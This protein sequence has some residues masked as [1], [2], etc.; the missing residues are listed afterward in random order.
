MSKAALKKTLTAMDKSQLVEIVCELYD[1]R[2]E[3]QEYLE[4]WLNPDPAKEL[5]MAK[6]KVMKMF[7][8]SSG[9]NRKEPSA[10]ALKKLVKDF[11][12]TVFDAD[13]VADLM[14]Y[15]MVQ[16][17]NWLCHKTSAFLSSEQ[18]M[19]RSFENART[20][21]EANGLESKYHKVFE[22]MGEWIDDFFANPPEPKRRGRRRRWW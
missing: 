22:Q 3:A 4:Y 16:H 18:S 8:F 10:T 11:S 20:Y 13:M 1:A 7:F 6:E 15:I 19:R 12:V 9:K 17:W 14:V 21:I 2:K 5:E